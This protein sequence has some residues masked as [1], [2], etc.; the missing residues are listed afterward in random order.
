[1]D[2]LLQ[3]GQEEL[4]VFPALALNEQLR[5][6]D[7]GHLSHAHGDGGVNQEVLLTGQD[8]LLE[9]GVHHA[10]RKVLDLMKKLLCIFL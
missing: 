2:A 4:Q 7:I 3:I 10:V 9:H 5:S 1:M 8:A 6:L